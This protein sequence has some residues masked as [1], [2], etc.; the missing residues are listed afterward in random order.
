MSV[1]AA[2]AQPDDPTMAQSNALLSVVAA[3]PAALQ[4]NNNQTKLKARQATKLTRKT[5]PPRQQIDMLVALH[6]Q[7][8]FAE[9]Q[10]LARSLTIRFPQHALGW[11]LLGAVLQQQGRFEEALLPLQ[12]AAELLPQ[13]AAA[14]GNLGLVLNALGR[15][16]QAEASYRRALALKPA[17]AAAQGNLGV[18]LR[19]Q[20]RYAEAEMRYRRAL[21]LKPND[22]VMHGN[23][24]TLLQDQ[25]RLAEAEARYRRVLELKPDDAVVHS[26]LLFTLSQNEAVDATALFAEHCRFGAQFEAPLRSQWQPHSNS[27]AP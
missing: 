26:A 19:N 16:P 13:D 17:Y 23:L 9:A 6:S 2:P 21:E 18:L 22:A 8:R 3:E 27:R 5:Q 11:T 20:G 10:T 12:T 15:L 1:S 7:G 4:S 24:G 14:Q 25:G